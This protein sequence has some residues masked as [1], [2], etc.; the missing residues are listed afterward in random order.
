MSRALLK[1]IKSVCVQPAWY[2]AD[3]TGTPDG[4][5]G[6]SYSHPELVYV[7]WDGVT[8][9]ILDMN[10]KEVLSNAEIMVTIEMAPGGKLILAEQT[11]SPPASP[12][13]AASIIKAVKVPMFRS[14]DTFAYTVYV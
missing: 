4:F 5:G 6:A 14:T 10:G 9:L 8:K 2:W 3:G 11:T 13:G 12:E 7:R 1:F